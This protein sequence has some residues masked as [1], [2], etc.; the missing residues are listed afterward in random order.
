MSEYWKEKIPDI[1]GRAAGCVILGAIIGLIFGLPNYPVESIGTPIFIHSFH[2]P[3]FNLLKSC[4]YRS[5][6]NDRLA[7]CR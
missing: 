3:F 2:V 7:Q 1:L 6:N 5:K 4:F